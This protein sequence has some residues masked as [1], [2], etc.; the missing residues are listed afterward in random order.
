[1]SPHLGTSSVIW[2][3]SGISSAIWYFSTIRYFGTILGFRRPSG[4]LVL[5]W[6]FVGHLVRRY[7]S[8]ISAAIWYVGTI[9]GFQ[10]PFRTS[11]QDRRSLMSR[12]RRTF[13]HC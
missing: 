9:L 10:R 13:R 4:T 6:D 5:F 7:Y 2:Y 1:M 8:G 3:L 11:K 12:T